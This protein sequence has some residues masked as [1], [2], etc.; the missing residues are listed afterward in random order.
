MRLSPL[1]RDQLTPEQRSVLEDIEN[2][3]RGNGR[4]GIGLIGPFGALVRAPAV[5]SEVQALGAA[6]RFASKL[7]ENIKEIAICT[8]G[9]F[10]QAKF[11]FSAHRQLAKN[12]GV[13]EQC[14]EQIRVGKQPELKGDELSSYQIANDLLQNHTLSDKTYSAGVAAFGESGVI[15]LVTTV[16]Y[17]G[18]IC[19]TLNSFHIPL[20]KGMDD[21][22]PENPA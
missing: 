1:T 11:E 4:K 15:E 6:V 17:Y 16:G 8:A 9:A 2:G 14:I 21:P 5:G 13:D 20:E 18:L 12:A 10:Y 22:F 7:P 19:F 3:P